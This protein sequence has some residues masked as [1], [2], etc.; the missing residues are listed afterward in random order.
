MIGEYRFLYFWHFSFQLLLAQAV[1]SW[2]LPK[3]SH[4]LLRLAGLLGAYMAVGLALPPLVRFVSVPSQLL[5]ILIHLFLFGLSLLIL[6]AVL[7]VRIQDAVFVGTA[8]Y[9]AQHICYALSCI[10]G[11]LLRTALNVSALPV[12]FQELVMQHLLFAVFYLAVYRALVKPGLRSGVI[13]R[14]DPRMVLLS[15][16]V[17][18]CSVG[19]SAFIQEM[20]ITPSYGSVLYWIYAAI[21]CSLGLVMQFSITTRNRLENDTQMLEQMLHIEK[22]QHEM[23]EESINII[24]LKCHD[25]KYQISAL[26]DMTSSAQREDSIRELE[27]SVMIYDSMAHCGNDSVDLIITEKSLICEQHQIKFSYLVDGQQLSFMSAVDLYALFHNALDNAIESVRKAPAEHRFISLRVQRHGSMLLLHLDNYCQ[28]PP[29]FVDGLPQTSKGDSN[30]H[31]FGTRSICYVAR[32]YGGE[33]RMNAS[34]HHFTLDIL[35]PLAQ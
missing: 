6:Y 11:Y 32:K 4:L 34:D 5:S 23:K 16:A 9:A 1:F 15:I 10:L 22:H 20:E 14:A 2:T 8:G 27:K 24:Q 28:D 25:L 12:L 17:L 33:V 7:D 21:S 29:R 18:G 26:K 30:Y 13:R 3:R 35:F 31:G 19:L